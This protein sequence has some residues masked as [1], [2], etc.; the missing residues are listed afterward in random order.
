MAGVGVEIAVEI[1]ADWVVAVV[2]VV[3]DDDVDDWVVIVEVGRGVFG[4]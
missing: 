2:A 3:D 4:D 1:V